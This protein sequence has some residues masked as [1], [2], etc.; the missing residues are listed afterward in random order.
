MYLTERQMKKLIK[1]IENNMSTDTKLSKTQIN[2]TMK[3]D[4]N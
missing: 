1:K 4:G 2:K 3:E